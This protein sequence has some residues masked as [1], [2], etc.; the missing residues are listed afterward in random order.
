MEECYF[1][2]SCRLKICNF[3]ESN[4]PPWVFLTFFKLQKWYQIAQHKHYN[5]ILGSLDYNI[6]FMQKC[7]EVFCLHGGVLQKKKKNC[8]ENFHSFTCQLVFVIGRVVVVRQ[9]EENQR[10]FMLVRYL[11][12]QNLERGSRSTDPEKFGYSQHYDIRNYF[13]GVS[14]VTLVKMNL[15]EN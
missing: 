14:C 8:P 9:E 1:Y 4:I 15:D 7:T 11:W 3:T 10:T 6:L 13:L 12:H 2:L 5:D